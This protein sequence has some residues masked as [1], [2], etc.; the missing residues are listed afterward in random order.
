MTQGQRLD[1]ASRSQTVADLLHVEAGE[2]RPLLL[3]WAHSFFAGVAVVP[4][5]AAGNALFLSQFSSD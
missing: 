3:L 1:T 2:G 5:L 4:L